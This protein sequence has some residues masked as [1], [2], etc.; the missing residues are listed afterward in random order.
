VTSDSLPVQAAVLGGELGKGQIPVEFMSG[1]V[2]QYS[3]APPA[4]II[5]KADNTR[6]ETPARS[7]IGRPLYPG[8]RVWLGWGP[9]GQCFIG[10]VIGRPPLPSGLVR[11]TTDQ[12]IANA[13][14]T[15]I[16]FNETPR[17]L[18]CGMVYNTT[19]DAF[20][21]PFT[22]L[23]D[24]GG[25]VFWAGGGTSGAARDKWVKLERLSSAGTL[26]ETMDQET[27][28]WWNPG[29][30]TQGPEAYSVKAINW[31]LNAGEMVRLRVHQSSP[32][33]G[34][35]NNPVTFQAQAIMSIGW[36]SLCDDVMT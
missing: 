20:V 21:V 29:V 18:Y 32:D 15:T 6:A 28:S 33:F 2:V 31:P 26:V 35:G 23:Y 7:V 5:V 4:R 12:G 27:R 10:G 24:A 22:A 8:M 25:T 30:T 1:S 16:D 34:F 9:D 13:T 11:R 36:K 14:E 3:E 17:F 19:V